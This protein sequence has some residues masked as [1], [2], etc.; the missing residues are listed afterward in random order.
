[1]NSINHEYGIPRK[2]VFSSIDSIQV[3]FR[4]NDEGRF[5]GFSA[6]ATC[7]SAD[8]QRREAR[9]RASVQLLRETCPV[10]SCSLLIIG[11]EITMYRELKPFEVQVIYYN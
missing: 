3:L 9:M 5:P 11:S 6:M 1:M 10:I 4:T 7:F 8:E 2:S